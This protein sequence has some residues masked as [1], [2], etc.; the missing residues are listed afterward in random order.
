MS[1][2]TSSVEKKKES[3]LRNKQMC[4]DYMHTDMFVWIL[5]SSVREATKEQVKKDTNEKH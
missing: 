4:N 3:K 2:N 5:S 1:K